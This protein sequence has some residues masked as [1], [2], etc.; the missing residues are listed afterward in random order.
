MPAATAST[1]WTAD[2]ALVWIAAVAVLYRLGGRGCS[3]SAEPWRSVSFAAGLTVLV[4]ALASPI[5]ELAD[6]LLWVHMVQHVLVLLVAPPLLA[7]ARPWNRIWHGLPLDWRRRVAGAVL[8]GGPTAPLRRAARGIGSPVASWSLFNVTLVGWHLPF[9]YD[10]TLHSPLAHGLEHAMF[11]ATGLLF[12]TRV[13]DSP[14]WRS[15]LT[16]VG[17]AAYA[18][19]ALV[20]GW[21]LALALAFAPEPLYAAY[22]A[23]T[24]RPGGISALADQRI[25]AGM[26]WVPG[27][28]PLTIAVLAILSRWL[29]PRAAETTEPRAARSVGIEGM[30]PRRS[31]R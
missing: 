18:G 24:A 28:I 6:R 22:A 2:P 31:S 16:A 30:R 9:A 3:R 26:M 5:H 4:I 29:D 14:P 1:S 20:V 15:P 10:A 17:R 23:E 11:F 21:I 8:R 19:L 13:I 7:L 12:W 27:S 25:A